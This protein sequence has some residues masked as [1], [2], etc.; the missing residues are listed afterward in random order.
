MRT[1]RPPY[2][3]TE[4]ISSPLLSNYLSQL[5]RSL[6]VRLATRRLWHY[7]VRGPAR[8]ASPPR[9]VVI[10]GNPRLVNT[11]SGVCS[12]TLDV[13]PSMETISPAAHEPASILSSFQSRDAGAAAR[14]TYPTMSKSR[15]RVRC[16]PGVCAPCSQA[17]TLERTSKDRGARVGGS[18]VIT[19]ISNAP[20]VRV[21]ERL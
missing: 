9:R 2:I 20:D 19:A 18:L 6:T 12:Q 13:C 10:A 4:S 16:S 8:P 21:L 17:S 11:A 14:A 5:P 7:R 1:L 15:R 3:L